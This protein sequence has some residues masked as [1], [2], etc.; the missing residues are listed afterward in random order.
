M[1]IAALCFQLSSAF[2]QQCV[3]LDAPL[4]LEIPHPRIAERDFVLRPLCDMAPSVALPLPAS[5]ATAT[6]PSP[7]MASLLSRL[8]VDA[9]MR[10]VLPLTR[11]HHALDK[12]RRDAAADTRLLWRWGERTFVM[13]I[14]N[15]TPD[16]FSD[17]GVH[18]NLDSAVAAAHRMLA[19]GVD[20]L[21]I[22]GVS[23]RPGADAVG[24]HDELARVVPLVRALRSGAH[25]IRVPISIDTQSAEVA[26]ACVAAGADMINDVSAGVADTRMLPTVAELGVPYCAMHMRGTPATMQRAPHTA[27]GDGSVGEVTRVVRAEL[28][29]RAEAALRAG[30]R[31][32]NIILDPGLG[33]CHHGEIWYLLFCPF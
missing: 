10:R 23:T 18:A 14:L 25:A 16:S 1:I 8:P 27:Y 11:G 12:Q 19:D 17:G 24:V 21:D 30:V 32:W 29:A 4:P 33:A 9:A 6:S 22:G 31:R 20:M 26:R 2:G 3:A 13:G 5:A 28:A 15:A 7:S